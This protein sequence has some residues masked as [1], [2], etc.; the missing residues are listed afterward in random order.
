[1]PDKAVTQKITDAAAQREQ[2]AAHER[3][4]GLEGFGLRFLA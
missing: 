1:M 4:A 3:S 2:V